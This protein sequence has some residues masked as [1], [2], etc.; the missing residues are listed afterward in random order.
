MLDVAYLVLSAVI[1]EICSYRLPADFPIDSQGR[2]IAKNAYNIDHDEMRYC[3]S[4]G[5][6]TQPCCGQ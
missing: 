5:S 6:K 4:C 2:T 1:E 3:I